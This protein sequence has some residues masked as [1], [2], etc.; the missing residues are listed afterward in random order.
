M[1][2]WRTVCSTD[3]QGRPH[4]AL[5][6]I[7]ETDYSPSMLSRLIEQ[8]NEDV[9]KWQAKEKEAT[10]WAVEGY[11]WEMDLDSQLREFV[12][13]SEGEWTTTV[14]HLVN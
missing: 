1:Q 4:H 5:E 9:A 11:R 7:A 10:E 14:Y 12:E 3:W 6:L 8:Q 2:L 13:G